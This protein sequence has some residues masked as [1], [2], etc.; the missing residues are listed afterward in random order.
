[1]KKRGF[2]YIACILAVITLITLSCTTAGTIVKENT[3]KDNT[4]VD[5]EKKAVVSEFILGPGD[6]LEITVYRNDD[7]NRKVQIPS[8]GIIFLP[9][10]GEVKTNGVGMRELRRQV[11]EGYSKYLL[12]PQ[13]NLEVISHRSQK[14]FVLGEVR[15]PGVFPIDSPISTL[16]AISRAGGF[17][18]DAKQTS[19]LLIRGDMAKPELARLDL[20][21][22]IKK[23]D[24]S[25]N[26]VLQ[27][28][29]VIYVPATYIANIERYFQRLEHII[30]PV[31]FLEQ[32]I[33]LYPQ[34]EDAIKG[35]TQ[36]K[37]APTIII[38][39]P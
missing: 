27:K 22:V 26:P 1:M 13:I 31:V 34:V 16:E 23:G 37:E 18:L 38:S 7:L 8:D 30:R 21:R 5:L 33:S 6:E 3:E 24:L 36:G 39:P 9:L 28:G 15:S 12:N 11:T 35:E 2:R 17:T 19:V 10:I 4:T 32:G 29:D 20:K 14:V 25:Q